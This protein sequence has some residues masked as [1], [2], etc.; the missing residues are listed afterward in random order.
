[1]SKSKDVDAAPLHGIVITQWEVQ[2][3]G[4]IWDRKSGYEVS[5][6]KCDNRHG[7]ESWGW[8]GPD[9]IIMFSNG[10]GGNELNPRTDDAIHF[11][12]DAA[13]KLCDALNA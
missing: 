7:H 10:V 5:V 4:D 11:A 12:L 8:G 1:M 6:L 9:K 13:Q 2:I 3:K